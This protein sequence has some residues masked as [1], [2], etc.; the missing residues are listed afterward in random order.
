MIRLPRIGSS[1]RKRKRLIFLSH[2]AVN[3]AT[4]S[5]AVRNIATIIKATNAIAMITDLTIVIET[6]NAAIALNVMTKTQKA[7]SPTTRRMIA[8]A[9]LQEKEQQGHA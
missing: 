8:S 1:Q 7:P 4:I 3:Q 2:V 6:I 9:I 5:I